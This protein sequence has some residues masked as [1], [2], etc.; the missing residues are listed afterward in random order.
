[1][2][3]ENDAGAANGTDNVRQKFFNSIVKGDRCSTFGNEDILHNGDPS[4]SYT[5]TIE[6]T[7]SG[8][9]GGGSH[10]S[11]RSVSNAAGGSVNLGCDLLPG[12]GSPSVRRRVVGEERH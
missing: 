7:T 2:S 4:H 5:V 9:H 11:Q 12:F 3:S 8:G 6:E 1:M 10:V